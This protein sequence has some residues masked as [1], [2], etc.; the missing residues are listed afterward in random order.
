[1]AK[2]NAGSGTSH[3]WWPASTTEAS[4]TDGSLP[5]EVNECLTAAIKALTDAS[6]TVV[7]RP[8]VPIRTHRSDQAH[9]SRNSTTAVIR[10]AIH[11]CPQIRTPPLSAQKLR[12][13]I[14]R[15]VTDA[16]KGHAT[17][18]PEM[19]GGVSDDCCS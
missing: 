13:K 10:D 17:R 14:Q 16:K 5:I 15:P 1:M 12:S 19:Q 7:F 6:S 18:D 4:A 11:V 3:L 8:T 2:R 9:N